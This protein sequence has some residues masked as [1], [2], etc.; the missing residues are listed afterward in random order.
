MTT[1]DDAP[2][3]D[4]E[5]RTEAL[6][7]ILRGLT[8]FTRWLV[9]GAE[10]EFLAGRVEEIMSRL[11][12]ASTLFLIEIT[13]IPSDNLFN[14]IFGGIDDETRTLEYLLFSPSD[15]AIMDIRKALGVE[16]LL[17][18]PLEQRE[19]LRTALAVSHAIRFVNSQRPDTDP[20]RPPRAGFVTAAVLAVI[21]QYPDRE[22]AIVSYVRDRNL[23]SDEIVPEHLDEYLSGT[24]PLAEGML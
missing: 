11:Q 17:D 16:T 14:T 24:A 23:V 5:A 22:E 7:I 19:G 8:T 20:A 18:A 12:H 9:D 10:N 13:V 1:A 4:S 6:E 21:L 15:V 2:L 3:T